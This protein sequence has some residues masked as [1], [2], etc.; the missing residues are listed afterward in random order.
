MQ[1]ISGLFY[2]SGHIWVEED[3]FICA[4]VTFRVESMHIYVFINEI[5]EAFISVTSLIIDTRS[6][7]VSWLDSSQD[8]TDSTGIDL[9]EFLVNTLKGNPRYAQ[10]THPDTA[11]LVTPASGRIL[12]W[13]QFISMKVLWLVDSLSG[14]LAVSSLLQ[15]SPTSPANSPYVSKTKYFA[16][17]WIS[18]CY[19]LVW[20]GL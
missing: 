20:P 16:H 15:Y 12:G 2:E 18:L 3:F 19:F 11:G 8:Y 7:C 9:H 14:V 5:R 1:V 10:H 4:Q 13:N 6:V 17:R